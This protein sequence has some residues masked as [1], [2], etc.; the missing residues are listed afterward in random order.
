MD[1]KKLVDSLQFDKRVMHRFVGSGKISNK[2]LGAHLDKLPDLQDQC[3]DIS[4][5]VYEH[6]KEAEAQKSKR[7]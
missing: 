7:S 4:E 2:E 3:E 5:I 6:F 1:K